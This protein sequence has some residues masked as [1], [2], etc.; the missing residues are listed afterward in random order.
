MTSRWILTSVV[1]ATVGCG[2][3]GTVEITANLN[4]PAKESLSPASPA[5]RME[6][7]T[8]SIDG[9]ERGDEAYLEL[10]AA[11][12]TAIFESYPANRSVAL[13]VQAFDAGNR[14][15]AS[16]TARFE[17][18]EDDLT[19]DLALN[20]SLAYVI[21]RQTCGGSCAPGFACADLGSGYRCVEEAATCTRCTGGNVCVNDGGGG[22]CVARYDFARSARA[23]R[24][25]YAI[26]LNARTLVE[27]IE[28]P[29]SNPQAVGISPFGSEGVLVTYVDGPAERP[30]GFVALLSASDHTFTKTVQLPC[31]QE[32]AV[33]RPGYRYAAVAG[34]G[35]VS[36]LDFG[37]GGAGQPTVLRPPAPGEQ[38]S[39]ADIQDLRLGG[40]ISDGLVG[41]GGR[42]AVFATS[43]GVA[44]IELDQADRTQ[45]VEPGDIAGASGIALA[46]DDR[47]AYATSSLSRVL[48]VM[49]LQE[50][51]LV[52]FCSPS[53]RGGDGSC[54]EDKGFAGVVGPAVFSE[55]TQRVLALEAG[56]AAQHVF[57][58]DIVAGT[59]DPVENAVSTL[60]SAADLAIG[61]GGRKA[62]VLAA[63]GL[64]MIALD[65]GAIEASSSFYPPD[66]DVRFMQDGVEVGERFQPL[67]IAI[68]NGQ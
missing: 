68:L 15:V 24:T 53:L 23:P 9:S 36:I 27:K 19:I 8:V 30:Q 45:P 25:I 12:R 7:I 13:E 43:G 52:P 56:E 26:D 47:L 17:V 6:R 39:C 44:L 55:K 11:E 59:G 38:G 28:L 34:G 22:A 66:P 31:P 60:A 32:L 51:A 54:P 50:K 16:A 20:R 21:H 37:E 14:L 67:K 10:G 40:R 2:G 62:V 65:R 29:G 18:D 58:F 49:D 41:A 61:P 33:G 57:G 1:L 42:K 3:G 48:Y 5:V 64:T 46:G 63:S 4:L 35:F